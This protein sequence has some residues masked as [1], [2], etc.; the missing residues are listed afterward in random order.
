MDLTHFSKILNGKQNIILI[1][2][3][4]K[5]VLHCGNYDSAGNC[6]V[7][8]TTLAKLGET[9]TSIEFIYDGRFWPRELFWDK[10][11]KLETVHVHA[12]TYHTAVEFN[13]LP[14]TLKKI[15]ISGL[16]PKLDEHYL[17]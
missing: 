6:T 15:I 1:I 16:A 14:K 11:I 8:Q 4:K 17:Q 10:F 13:V 5:L 9:V 2:N 3:N 12:S 7:D